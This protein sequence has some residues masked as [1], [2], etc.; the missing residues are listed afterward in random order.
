MKY[1]QKY[2]LFEASSDEYQVKY[3][4]FSKKIR[5]ELISE[6][7]DLMKNQLNVSSLKFPQFQLERHINKNVSKSRY[8]DPVYA[9]KP[10]LEE[11]YIDSIHIYQS[12]DNLLIEWFGN[13]GEEQE[14]LLDIDIND[15]IK[16]YDYLEGISYMDLFYH[17]IE[18]DFD[19]EIAE[20]VYGN[21]SEFDFDDFNRNGKDIFEF[22]DTDDS[23]FFI[24]IKESY[25]FQK[26]VAET[27]DDDKIQWL[28]DSG[29]KIDDKLND[30]PK[31]GHLFQSRD[32]GLM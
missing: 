21:I 26:W 9:N 24:N 20:L 3:D 30:D 14:Q 23:D 18:N 31:Y 29:V 8:G 17:Y 1:L 5:K 7:I 12:Q 11:V 19:V 25:Y 6:I 4:D 28:L 10:S 22:L 2:K 27:E 13:D 32:I 15:I 16:I